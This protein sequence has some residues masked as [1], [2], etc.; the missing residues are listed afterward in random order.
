MANPTQKVATHWSDYDDGSVF[1]WPL[2]PDTSTTYQT[3]ELIGRN[4]TGYATHFDDAAPLAFLGVLDGIHQKVDT[5]DTGLT[6][7]ARIKR[8]YRLT[9]PLATGTA[10]RADATNGA[11]G[12]LVYVQYSGACLIDSSALTYANV[13][14][15][16]VDIA[17]AATQ[18]GALTSTVAVQ[19]ETVAEKRTGGV[20]TLAATGNQTINHSDVGKLVIVPNTANLTLSLPGVAN[21]PLGGEITF[22]K[23]SSDAN[24]ITLDPLASETIN[25]GTTVATMDAQYDTITIINLGAGWGIKCQKI[26]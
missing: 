23:S 26:A 6:N 9:V 1:Y 14:G 5:A 12:K 25:G 4:A 13:L 11:I 20:R 17:D 19:I 7:L 8:A 24:P 22:F 10:G 15:R 3:G 18:P 21:L 2:D 16:I